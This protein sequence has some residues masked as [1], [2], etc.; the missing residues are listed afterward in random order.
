MDIR[1]YINN[2]LVDVYPEPITRNMSIGEVGNLLTINSSYSYTFKLPATSKNIAIFEML[3][4]IGH[5]SSTPYQNNFASYYE[6]GIKII[7]NGFALIKKSI[8]GQFDCNLIDGFISVKNALGSLTL[9]DLNLSSLTHTLTNTNFT[10]SM[11]NTSG[12]IYALADFGLGAYIDSPDTTGNKRIKT[13][14]QAPCIY[15]HTI[16]DKIFSEAGITIISEEDYRDTN[17]LAEVLAPEEGYTVDTIGQTILAEDYIPAIEQIQFV[18]DIVAR[19]GLFI[20]PISETEIQIEKIENVL[21]G[22]FGLKD[23]SNKVAKGIT[24]EY[25]SGFAQKNNFVYKYI[26]DSLFQDYDGFFEI[27]N[28]TIEA[29]KDVYTSIYEIPSA[30]SR[31]INTIG[32]IKLAMFDVKIRSEREEDG[33]TVFDNVKTSY[34]IFKIQKAVGSDYGLEVQTLDSAINIY[35]GSS[36]FAYLSLQALTLQ[37]YINLNYTKYS[38]MLNN[39]RKITIKTLLTP[40]EIYNLDWFELWYLKQTGKRYLLNSIKHQSESFTEVELIEI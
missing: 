29:S 5:N 24:E 19:H 23:Y 18:K 12:Y 31:L 27:S 35:T 28:E 11:S 1:L 15:I 4:T 13:E 14:T 7:S 40:I 38:E 25:L 30:N 36:E 16:W 32:N 22:L 6:N 21:N 2:K 33:D 3:G 8:D 39:Y 20:R 26:D 37:S 9:K 34:K 17:F 10:T